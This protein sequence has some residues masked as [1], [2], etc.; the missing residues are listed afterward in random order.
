MTSTLFW[1]PVD[2]CQKYRMDDNELIGSVNQLFFRTLMLPGK[3]ILFN[4][5]YLLIAVYRPNVRA[6]ICFH[7]II[8][9][10]EYE[11]KYRISRVIIIN[12]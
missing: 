9:S 4:Y 11:Q 7:E 3:P 10:R 12:F 2:S 6:V 8:T 1:I 5:S